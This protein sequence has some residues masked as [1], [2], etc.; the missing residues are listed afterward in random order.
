MFYRVIRSLL[1][2]VFGLEYSAFALR[3]PS[4]SMDFRRIFLQIKQIP[5]SIFKTNK[6]RITV[7]VLGL[8]A[9][10]PISCIL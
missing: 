2:T 3:N 10:P 1:A 6:L 8:A 9:L 5:M 4:S 7:Y